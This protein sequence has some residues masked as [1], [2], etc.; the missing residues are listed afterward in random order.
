MVTIMAEKAQ[1]PSSSVRKAGT[2]TF[3]GSR[4]ETIKIE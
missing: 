2:Y 3:L 4:R 1:Q